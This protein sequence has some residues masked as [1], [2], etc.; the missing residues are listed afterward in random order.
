MPGPI[1]PASAPEGA[2]GGQYVTVPAFASPGQS[3]PS[4][5]R[6]AEGSTVVY[7]PKGWRWEEAGDEYSKSVSRLTAATM[8][9]AVR[10]I[11]SSFGT[12]L[13]IRGTADTEPPFRGETLGDTVR[14]QDAQTLDIVAEWKWNGSSWERMRVTS[15]QISNLDVGKLT[16]GAAN[17]AEL[18]ARKIAADV[19]RFLEITTDQL[20]VTGNASF[21]NA[22]AHHVWTKVITAGQGE[23]EKIRAGMLEANSVSASN[24]QA[25]AIDGQVI[26]GATIQTERTYNRGLKLSSDGL[27]VYDAR[28]RS[29]LDVN[30]HTGAIEISGHLSRQ[31]SWSKVWFNDVISTRTGRDVGTDGSKWGCGLAFNSLE[32]NWG[33]GVIAMLKDQSGDPSIRIQAPYLRGVGDE[34]PYISVG[35]SYVTMY[36]P[37]GDTLFEF[38]AGG[39]RLRA[40]DIYWWANSGGFSYGTNSDNKPRLY[41]GPNTVHIRPMGESLPRFWGDRNSTTMQYTG[42]HQVWINGSGVNIT[43]GK[44]FSMR[45]PVLTAER[46]GLW[47]EHSCTESPYDGIEYWENVTLDGDGRYRWTLPDYVPRI[48]SKKAPWVVFANEGAR[49]VLDRS[50]PEEWHVDVTG[51][52]GAVVAVLVKGARQVDQDVDEHGEPIMRDYA[53]ESPW[54]IGAPTP[55]AYAEGG[56]PEDDMALGGG[57]YGPVTKPEGI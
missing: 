3:L 31:D 2:R 35:T 52:P 21:V 47:L 32:D 45:V 38:K 34:V 50:N 57:M 46:G 17:I 53:R 51:T 27:R 18:T 41:V 1:N 54:H 12:V 11:R 9:S 13:Y 7:S 48:A 39:V 24:I 29:V 49:G 19:G 8:E 37:S 42:K 40:Q 16:V 36:T 4:N 33:D 55:P 6:T 25:G 56:V 30:A 43:G 44:K 23:F 10:R 15:E 5:S 28:G 14:V 20:T 26:T 22:T